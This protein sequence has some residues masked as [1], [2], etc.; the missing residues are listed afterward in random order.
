MILLRCSK[1]ADKI[2]KPL[3]Y[4]SE[5]RAELN[6]PLFE[7]EVN[8]MNELNYRMDYDTRREYVRNALAE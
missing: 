4:Q 6:Q 5:L 3:S 7:R 2:G 8:K 1:G